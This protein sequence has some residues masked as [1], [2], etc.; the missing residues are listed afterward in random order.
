MA[1]R[2]YSLGLFGLA[3]AAA[4]DDAAAGGRQNGTSRNH[5]AGANAHAAGTALDM[6]LSSLVGW[7]WCRDG[8]VVDFATPCLVSVP[9]CAG[10]LSY[11][12][13][14]LTSTGVRL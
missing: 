8:V 11:N 4:R 7:C 5:A 9:L 2:T 13:R 10:V 14:P 1:V 12:R 6:K 3:D